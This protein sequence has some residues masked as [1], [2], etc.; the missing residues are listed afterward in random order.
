MNTLK[1]LN[2]PVGACKDIWYA[3]FTKDYT[4]TV[5]TGFDK[6]EKDQKTYFKSSGDSRVL[7]AKK[8]LNKILKLKSKS[9][10]SFTKPDTLY[11]VGVVRG[12]YP[13]VLPD[14]YTP[15]HMISYGYFKKETR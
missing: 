9:G 3:G 11:L 10:L 13:Y 12:V 2:Y 5:W 15:S 1:K 6:H 4:V 7:V 8:I 14:E